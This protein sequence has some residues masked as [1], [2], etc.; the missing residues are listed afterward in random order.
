M[1]NALVM[2]SL[3]LN[4]VA[5]ALRLGA[6]YASSSMSF[7]GTL[8]ASPSADHFLYFSISIVF[9]CLQQSCPHQERT[10]CFYQQKLGLRIDSSELSP[11]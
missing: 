6:N 5:H 1:L 2:Q 11:S 9:F 3:L 8:F 4:A 10:K 7:L